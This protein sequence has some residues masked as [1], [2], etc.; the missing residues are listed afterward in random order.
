MKNLFD[1]F[2]GY[3]KGKGVQD[4]K[5]EEAFIVAMI[6][7]MARVIQDNGDTFSEDVKNKLNNINE[8]IKTPDGFT[9][10]NWEEVSNLTI[11]KDKTIKQAIEEELKNYIPK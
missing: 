11:G 1:Q 10:I 6:A 2:K 9:K 4:N 8:M 7:S 5:I 3:Y